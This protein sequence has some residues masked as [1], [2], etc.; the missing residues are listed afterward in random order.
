[1]AEH[2]QVRV[3]LKHM[4]SCVLCLRLVLVD[5]SVKANSSRHRNPSHAHSC[6]EPHQGH[7]DQSMQTQAACYRWCR[8]SPPAAAGLLGSPGS[9]LPAAAVPALLAATAAPVVGLLSQPPA[10]LLTPL[11]LLGRYQSLRLLSALSG[12]RPSAMPSLLPARAWPAP[13]LEL[14][15]SSAAWPQALLV[16]ASEPSVSL[17]GSIRGLAASKPA[18]TLQQEAT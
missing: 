17:R 18:G 8:A 6:E 11:M 3:Q 14:A 16:L 5:R 4:S 15:S 7:K 9:G 1:V 13:L 12:A 10:L 2:G